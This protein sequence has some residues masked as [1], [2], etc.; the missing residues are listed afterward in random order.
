MSAGPRVLLM[1]LS[2]RTSARG[3]R[4]MSGWL[5]RASVVVFQ[6]EEPDK[7][8]NPVWDVFVSTPEPRPE[9]QQSKPEARQDG[10]A[11]PS[12]RQRPEAVTQRAP[13]RHQERGDGW[14]GS[15]YRRPANGPVRA[16]AGDDGPFYDDDL[17]DIGR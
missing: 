12:A 5:G 10:P 8:G 17:A 15:Q 6:A 4:Y 13:A 7:F 16:P 1:Q 11:K 9:Q 3:N 14:R 2:E